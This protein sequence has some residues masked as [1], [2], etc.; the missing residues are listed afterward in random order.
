MFGILGLDGM[1]LGFMGWMGSVGWVGVWGWDLLEV[2]DFGHAYYIGVGRFF[3]VF[4]DF[5][6]SR[7]VTDK[8][9]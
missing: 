3:E 5:L 9:T 6:K 8:S 4:C 2:G 1:G 7:Q